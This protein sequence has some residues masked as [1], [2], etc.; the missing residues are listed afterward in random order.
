MKKSFATV[1]QPHEKA[2]LACERNQDKHSLE[3][4]GGFEKVGKTDT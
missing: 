1:V 2:N 4:I 3:A